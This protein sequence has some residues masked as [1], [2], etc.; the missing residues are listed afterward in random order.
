ML[1]RGSA[2]HPR[3]MSNSNGYLAASIDLLLGSSCVGCARAGPSLCSR[4]EECFQKV[5]QRVLPTPAP[6]GL[7]PAFAVT[8]YDGVAKVVLLAHKEQGRL[9]LARPLGRAL[10]LSCYGLLAI[11]ESRPGAVHLVPVPSA[12]RRVRERGHDPLLRVAR[13]CRRA[14]RVG[15]VVATVQPLLRAVRAVQDQAGLSAPARHDNL[16]E[17]FDV[18]GRRCPADG[19]VVVVDDIITTGATAAEASRALSE[20]GLPVAGVAVVAATARRS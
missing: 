8:A 10:A 9:S 6:A 18:V 4:C 1:Q 19:T 15:G 14:M 17:A 5:P 11:R 7:P 20:A 12:P 13:E 2:R 3:A 16:R